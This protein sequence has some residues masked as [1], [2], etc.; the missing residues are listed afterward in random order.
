M[1]VAGDL[2]RLASI[3]AAPLA[4]P[5]SA[6]A[7]GGAVQRQTDEGPRVEGLVAFGPEDG[8][9]GC[10]ARGVGVQTFGEVAERRA[11]KA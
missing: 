8:R 4:V 5:L 2:F 10:P 7:A 3:G 6:S 9:G 1:A 11:E